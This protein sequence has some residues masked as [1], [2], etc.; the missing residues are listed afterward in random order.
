MLT[1]IQERTD[2]QKETYLRMLQNDSKNINGEEKI[3]LKVMI[4]IVQKLEK[5]VR[6][7]VEKIHTI[8]NRINEKKNFRQYQ[9]DAEKERWNT[10]SYLIFFSNLHRQMTRTQGTQRGNLS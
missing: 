2:M 8:A 7:Y 1:Y 9:H 3:K 6:T 4:N 5:T 10:V